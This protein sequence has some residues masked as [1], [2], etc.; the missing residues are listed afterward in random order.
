MKFRIEGDETPTQKERA[1]EMAYNIARSVR[2]DNESLV[3]DHA[4]QVS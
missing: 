1:T 2:A 3:L 4:G